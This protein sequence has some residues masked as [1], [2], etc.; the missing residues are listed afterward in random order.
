MLTSSGGNASHTDGNISHTLAAPVSTHASE[1]H[2]ENAEPQK[3]DVEYLRPAMVTNRMTYND[4]AR[5][6]RCL[7]K[8]CVYIC[9]PV[10]IAV[11]GAQRLFVSIAS[12][13]STEGYNVVFC[14]NNDVI[15]RHYFSTSANGIRFLNVKSARKPIDV[16]DGSVVLCM[17]T[18]AGE[19]E[20]FMKHNTRAR[21]LYYVIH[22]KSYAFLTSR[23]RQ[24][25]KSHNPEGF[26]RRLLNRD[27]ACLVSMDEVCADYINRKFE[28]EM[29]ILPVFVAEKKVTMKKAVDRDQ[30]R[31]GFLGR[32]DSDKIFAVVNLLD[33]L[34]Q[35]SGD[36]KKTI[37]IIG[38]GTDSCRINLDFY[39]SEGIEVLMP[40]ALTGEVKDNYI[41][42]NIDIMF[43]AG[44]ACLEQPFNG[45]PS[46]MIPFSFTKFYNDRDFTYL[47]NM[48]GFNGGYYVDDIP[49][50][51]NKSFSSFQDI[52][53]DVY[54]LG[55][56][57][58][59]GAKCLDYVS[60]KHTFNV[61][62]E[63]F[64]LAAEV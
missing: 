1:P 47:F 51:K 21:Y 63:R 7:A 18:M 43:T 31:I 46:V 38:A 8:S 22:P 50:L 33:C 2:L 53:T 12:R 30:I 37:H 44:L 59:L 40:G 14:D 23:L 34:Q 10:S 29:P 19:I 20:E 35:L 15:R 55:R 9:L 36:Y 60:R 62:L 52:I 13:L 48:S 27:N 25:N 42:K 56:V 4:P 16:P 32:L 26:V 11:G 61:F 17:L 3:D 41:V 28:V 54:E 49:I 58:E 57:E 5:Q 6:S 45:I 39:K 64:R 24:F